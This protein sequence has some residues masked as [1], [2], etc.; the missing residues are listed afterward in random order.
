MSKIK[1]DCTYLQDNGVKGSQYR[2]TFLIGGNMEFSVFFY[3][4]NGQDD[5]VFRAEKC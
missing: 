1:I 3:Y 2:K 5:T 4:E